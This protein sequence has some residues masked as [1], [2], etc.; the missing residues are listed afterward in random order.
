MNKHTHCGNE[1]AAACALLSHATPT[2]MATAET[3]TSPLKI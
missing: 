3:S 1:G 2:N